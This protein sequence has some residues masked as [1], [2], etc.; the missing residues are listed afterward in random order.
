[1]SLSSLVILAIGLAMD[2]AAVSASCGLATPALRARHFVSVAVYFG[3]F[4]ALMPLLGFLLGSRIGSAVAAWDHWIA[5]LLLG[6]IGLKM[7]Y[8]AIGA[9]DEAAVL[10]ERNVFGAR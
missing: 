8:E 3:G 2:A 5:F 4:Q 1:M 10:R 6:G 7:I 9:A